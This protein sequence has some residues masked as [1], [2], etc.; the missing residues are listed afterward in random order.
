MIRQITDVVILITLS[1]IIL[2]GCVRSIS[3]AWDRQVKFEQAIQE[4]Y[5]QDYR[6]FELEKAREEDRE[7]QLTGHCY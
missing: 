2:W 6:N 7:E 5:L 4:P 1:T 3:W